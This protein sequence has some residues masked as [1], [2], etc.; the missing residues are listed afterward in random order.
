MNTSQGQPEERKPPG[1]AGVGQ[2]E[3][4]GPT[5]DE[6]CVSQLGLPEL[7]P[8][9]TDWQIYFSLSQKPEIKMPAGLTPSEGC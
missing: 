2:W 1:G 3:G 4:W 5:G 7:E 6:I 8:S 9:A